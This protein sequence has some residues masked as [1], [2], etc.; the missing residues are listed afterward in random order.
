MRCTGTTTSRPR[1]APMLATMSVMRIS[2]GRT[3]TYATVPTFFPSLP[4]TSAP[5]SMGFSVPGASICWHPFHVLGSGEN[6]AHRAPE[7]NRV[8]DGDEFLDGPDGVW[9]GGS[10][11]PAAVPGDACFL[12]IHGQIHGQ[13]P[14]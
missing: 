11:H 3:T 8:T 14:V 2:G 5:T 9:R 4:M 13:R 1:M 7:N 6:T 10:R 12:Y